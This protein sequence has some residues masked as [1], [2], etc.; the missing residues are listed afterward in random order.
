MDLLHSWGVELAVHLQIK[1][2]DYESVF[3]WV[4]SLADLHTTFFVFFPVWFHLRRD[5][6]VKLIWVAVVGDWLN[7]VLKWVLFGERPYWWVHETKFYGSMKHPELQQFSMTCETGPG[8]PSG[9]AMGSAA[10]GYVMI[11]ALLSIL[12]E[13]K[14]PPLIYRLVQLMLWMFLGLV[15][16]L[17]CMSRVYLAAHFPHQVICGVISGIIVAETFSRVQWIYSASLKKYFSITLFLLSFAVGFY[18]LLKALGVDLLWTLEKAQKWCINPAWV[19][20]DAT[21]FASLLRNMGTLFGLGL[22]LHL[23]HYD[24]GSSKKHTCICFRIGCIGVSLVLLQLLDKMTFSSSSQLF[25]LLSFCKS[26]V[27]LLL[28]TALVPGIMYWITQKSKHEKDM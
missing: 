4:S 1:Y 21:P 18:V 7:L 3:H 6:A 10:V 2:Q 26:A 16:L 23:S 19:L 24:P 12:A 22:G 5:V 11:T 28:P 25:Y 13:R 9:H 20:M 14:L 17:V 27:A 15:E 8:S